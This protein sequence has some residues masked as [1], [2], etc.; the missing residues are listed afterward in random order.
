MSTNS[1]TLTVRRRRRRPQCWIWSSSVR[2]YYR[3]RRRRRRRRRHRAAQS[4]QFRR[5]PLPP[6]PSQLS[7]LRPSRLLWTDDSTRT[8]WKAPTK[9]MMMMKMTTISVSLWRLRLPDHPEFLLPCPVR[10]P[11]PSPASPPVVPL[12][13]RPPAGLQSTHKRRGRGEAGG[14][15]RK[16]FGMYCTVCSIRSNGQTHVLV[17][18][19]GGRGGG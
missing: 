8:G 14:E 7:F 1:L 4:P 10:R 17:A 18:R 3:R 2:R 12:Q 19:G 16:S 15:Q 6:R 9:T 13:A 11:P 5:R